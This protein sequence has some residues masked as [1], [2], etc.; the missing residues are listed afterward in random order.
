MNFF[1]NK[2]VIF[3]FIYLQEDN[4]N[5]KKKRKKVMKIQYTTIIMIIDLDFAIIATFS[6]L[7]LFS[8]RVSSQRSD[9]EYTSSGEYI[10]LSKYYTTPPCIK[11][12]LSRRFGGRCREKSEGS[13]SRGFKE[14]LNLCRKGRIE[15]SWK[16]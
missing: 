14:G 13:F 10:T 1:P 3:C 5:K 16:A 12:V 9:D 7:L 6:S 11:E 8:E 15:N 4:W 2:R